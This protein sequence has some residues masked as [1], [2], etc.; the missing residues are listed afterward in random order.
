MPPGET[1]QRIQMHRSFGAKNAPQDDK[2]ENVS[3]G[4]KIQIGEAFS[5][6]SLWF[7]QPFRQ[8]WLGLLLVFLAAQSALKLKYYREIIQIGKFQKNQFPA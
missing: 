6:Q 4:V 3:F 5:L 8:G 7:S 1:W 2:R